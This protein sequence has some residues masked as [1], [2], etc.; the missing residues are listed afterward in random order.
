MSTGLLSQ[1]DT[2]YSWVDSA[3]DPIDPEEIAARINSPVRELAIPIPADT[4]RPWV[5]AVSAA[6]AVLVLVGGVGLALNL[7]E[8][9]S[10]AMTTP[11]EPLSSSV[12]SRVPHD[13]S[14]FGGAFMQSVAVGGPGLVA[15]GGSDPGGGRWE[16]NSDTDAAVWIS[17]DGFTWSR[18]PHDEDVFGGE[19]DQVMNRVIAGGPG[20]VAVGWDGPGILDDSPDVD[21]AVWTS[22]DGYTWSRVPNDE[23]TFGGAWIE[24]VTV[25]APGLIAVGGTGGYNTD[26]DAAVWTSVDGI[27]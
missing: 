15:V 13:D 10:P 14:V 20:L 12:W 7:D 5:V 23:E 4:R 9:N 27:T 24:S 2:Y 21:A 22:V 18:V 8:P 11:K 16:D 25:G 6:A 26:G 1:L 17:L 3:Q 19:H